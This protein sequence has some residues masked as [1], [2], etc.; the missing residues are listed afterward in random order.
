MNPKAKRVLAFV[1]QPS[2]II[3]ALAL[4]DI[5][6]VWLRDSRVDWFFVNYHG[7]Y[8]DTKEVWWRTFQF[9]PQYALHLT[10]AV[11]I[12]IAALVTLARRTRRWSWRGVEQIV[13]RERR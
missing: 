9:Q 4:V 7:Y 11:L 8:A 6:C 10:I 5:V 3:L 2:A 1:A 12:L 13:G